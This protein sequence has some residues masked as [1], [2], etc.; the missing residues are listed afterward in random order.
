MWLM[1]MLHKRLFLLCLLVLLVALP[2][3]AQV[4][5]DGVEVCPQPASYWLTGEVT[6]PTDSLI[7]GSQSYD[8]GELI[9]ILTAD[10]SADV[11]LQLAQQLISIKLNVVA[12][13]DAT[14]IATIISEADGLLA[15]FDGKLPYD[16]PESAEMVVLANTFQVFNDGLLSIGCDDDDDEAPEVTPEPEITP[17]PGDDDVAD[18]EDD[19][20]PIIIVIEGPVTAIQVDVVTTVTIYNID[21]VIQESSDLITVIQVGDVI[22][23]EGELA[24]GNNLVFVGGSVNITVVIVNINI[25]FISVD[26]YVVDGD[27]WR[28]REDCSNPPPPWAPARGWRERCESGGNQPGRGR[29]SDDDDDDDDDDD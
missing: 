25:V 22:R 7:L 10:A 5:D 8:Q 16:V 6:W 26:V 12:G 2:I 28:D 19:S 23:V 3:T 11:S 29:N 17:E 27:V 4:D 18:D 13:A 24:S 14:V 1:D 9:A 15:G 21:I 20:M